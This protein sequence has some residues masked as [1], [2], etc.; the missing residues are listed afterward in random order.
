MR[1]ETPRNARV[2]I[3][4]TLDRDRVEPLGPM[5]SDPIN[6]EYDLIKGPRTSGRYVT[7]ICAVQ[8]EKH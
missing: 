5:Y 4:R 3:V 2:R 1:L 7:Q 8:P 6:D